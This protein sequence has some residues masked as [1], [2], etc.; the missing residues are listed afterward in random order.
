MY[1]FPNSQDEGNTSLIFRI[2]LSC[3]KHEDIVYN[4]QRALENRQS[5][6]IHSNIVQQV[7]HLVIYSY[8]CNGRDIPCSLYHHP[9]GVDIPFIELLTEHRP[10]LDG[11]YN[12]CL[13]LACRL[14]EHNFITAS[15]LSVMANVPTDQ[16]LDNHQMSASTPF[17]Y[18]RSQ[19]EL[20]R[21]DIEKR[22][23]LRRVWN[24]GSASTV[25]HDVMVVIP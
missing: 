6:Q 7:L 19:E 13:E 2:L 17:I 1:R 9:C 20:A 3:S 12:Q 24:C 18:V 25:F 15:I 22:P 14:T 10:M 4:E 21:P 8:I 23:A 11:W 16:C 5:I